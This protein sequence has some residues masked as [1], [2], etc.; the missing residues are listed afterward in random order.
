[1]KVR[2]VSTKGIQNLSPIEITAK[3]GQTYLAFCHGKNGRGRWEVR[4]PLGKRDFPG[5]PEDISE[6]Q[7]FSLIDLKKKD[8]RKNNLY[9]LGKGE[10]DNKYLIFWFLSP[11]FRG[12]ADY[13]V[14]GKAKIISI[15]Y[16]AQGLAGRAGGADCPVVLVEG[17]CILKWVR[18]GR[19]YG[20]PA[21]WVANFDG[22]KWEI[23]SIDDCVL[24]D[25]V[26]A[27]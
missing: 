25:A 27:Y 13:K 20:D 18:H 19:L 23:S 11:G 9:L 7:E 15:G 17:P 8:A 24:E 10:K 4:F 21:E 2:S 12:S 26:F 1:V 6:D 14:S 16:E 22:E 3:N 5:K